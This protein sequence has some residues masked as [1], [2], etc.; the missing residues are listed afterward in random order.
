[1]LARITDHPIHRIEESLPWNL[2]ATC[3]PNSQPKEESE[4]DSSVAFSSRSNIAESPHEIAG[5]ETCRPR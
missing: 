4:A 1:V 3:C 2:A 5:N